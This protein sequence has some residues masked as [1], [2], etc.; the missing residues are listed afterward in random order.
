MFKEKENDNKLVI[1]KLVDG[2][3]GIQIIQLSTEN[4]RKNL[5]PGNL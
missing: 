1:F 3:N 2:A 5:T 4:A